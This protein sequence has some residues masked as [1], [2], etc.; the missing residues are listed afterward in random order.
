MGKAAV[1]GTAYTFAYL[2]L[3]S[4]QAHDFYKQPLPQPSFL[5]DLPQVLLEES[6]QL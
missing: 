2:M 5:T 3:L 1:K 6:I 4:P